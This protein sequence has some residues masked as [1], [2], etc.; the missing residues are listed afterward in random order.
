MYN[1]HDKDEFAK[2]CKIIIGIC[3]EFLISM[4]NILPAH[5]KLNVLSTISKTITFQGTYHYTKKHPI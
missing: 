2:F 4:G 3:S 1:L 5:I